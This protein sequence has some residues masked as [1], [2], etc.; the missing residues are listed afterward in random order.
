[1]EYCLFFPIA[2]S[3]VFIAMTGT[4]YHFNICGIN[5]LYIYSLY[6]S[7]CEEVVGQQKTKKQT[8]THLNLGPR[9]MS[10]EL[11]KI[12]QTQRNLGSVLSPVHLYSWDMKGKKRRR[13]KNL[14]LKLHFVLKYEEAFKKF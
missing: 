1:M 5:Q 9:N 10:K 11:F 12:S 3:F 8:Q 4:S 2:V 6:C 7:D 13:K 14:G